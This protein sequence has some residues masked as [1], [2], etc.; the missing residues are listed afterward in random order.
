MTFRLIRSQRLP[1]E[2]EKM[3]GAYIEFAETQPVFQKA[4]SLM[5]K[6]KAYYGREGWKL[7]DEIFTLR[8]ELYNAADY[9]FGKHPG[10]SQEEYNEFSEIARWSRSKDK[11]RSK[12]VD[13]EDRAE[14]MF[15]EIIRGEK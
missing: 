2:P 5:P 11:F 6:V 8:Y 1:D 9:I 3:L 13:L 4:I 10:L 12:V 15:L 7:L 14:D